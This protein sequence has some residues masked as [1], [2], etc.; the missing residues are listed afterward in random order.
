MPKEGLI[1]SVGLSFWIQ[2][3][4][5]KDAFD[6]QMWGLLHWVFIYIILCMYV[7]I[8]IYTVTFFDVP[9]QLL[10]SKL[11]WKLMHSMSPET[12]RQRLTAPWSSL[13]LSQ[14]LA[15]RTHNRRNW[16]KLT[17]LIEMD[18]QTSVIFNDQKNQNHLWDL[19]RAVPKILRFHCI[20]G[21]SCEKV[22]DGFECT[23]S[24][25]KISLATP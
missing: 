14:M 3:V 2:T 20:A 22:L 16:I 5:C 7:Y 19:V 15:S 24:N 21:K 18:W 11:H 25:L 8:Y 9:L 10:A 13:S 17:R 23:G 6:Q 1:R 4:S 12:P